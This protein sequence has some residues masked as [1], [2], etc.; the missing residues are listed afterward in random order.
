MGFESVGL[1]NE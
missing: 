1:V